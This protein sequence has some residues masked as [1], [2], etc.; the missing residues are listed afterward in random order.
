MKKGEH[1]G[2]ILDQPHDGDV[3]DEPD[4]DDQPRVVLAFE[5]G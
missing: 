5:A 1:G 4:A 3:D 2:D